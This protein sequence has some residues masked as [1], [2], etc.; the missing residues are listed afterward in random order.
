[1]K[2]QEVANA[3]EFDT[4]LVI[5]SLRQHIEI[6]LEREQLYQ[7]RHADLDQVD[8]CALEWLEETARKPE[9]DYVL[10]PEFLAPAGDVTNEARIHKR[11]TLE[12][13]E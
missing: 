12:V 10:V 6:A 13:I 9:R 4:R 8:T 2:N 5:E 7:A 3:L 11:L 1:M